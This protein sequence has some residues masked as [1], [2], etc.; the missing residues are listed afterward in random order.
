M[1]GKYLFG[2]LQVC[3]LLAWEGNYGSFSALLFHDTKMQA[4]NGLKDNVLTLQVVTY[5]YSKS[6]DVCSSTNTELIYIR[7][8][9]FTALAVY[10]S[11]LQS[12]DRSSLVRNTSLTHEPKDQSGSTRIQLIP[13]NSLLT[14]FFFFF[15]PLLFLQIPLVEIL[16]T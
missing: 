12:Q 9:Y 3:L 4:L 14:I 16:V 7:Y 2:K 5:F 1:S 13:S 11:R 15:S 10:F 6:N 8:V